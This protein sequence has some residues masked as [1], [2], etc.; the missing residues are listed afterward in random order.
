MVSAMTPLLQKHSGIWI[1][2]PGDGGEGGDEQRHE[3]LAEWGDKE[4]CY[5]LELPADVARGFYEG[6]ANQTLWP[7]FHSFPSRLRFDAKGWDSY[8][9]ANRAFCDAVVA[10]HQPGDLIWVHDYHLMLLPKMLRAALPDAV[11]G[12]FLH[13]PF[14]SADI[15][16]ILPRREDVLEG[17]LGAD[18][19][20]FHTH[21]HVQQF[22]SSVLRVLG[23]ESRINEIAIGNR[24]V[25]LEA[26]PIGIAP[27]EYTGLLA[28]DQVTAKHYEEFVSNYKGQRVIVAIDRLDYTKGV[29]ERL[30]SFREL[31]GFSPELKEKVTLIQVAVRP[32]RA[33]ICIRICAQK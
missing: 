19:L 2:W 4:H 22:R 29:P 27:D 20:A 33:S 26:L 15:F 14:P 9:E 31:L 12:F 6:Y 1:G 7:V 32:E 5:A 30:R 17:L 25:H 3:I 28:K 23:L 13:I 18:L 24:A 8:V 21:N 11:I 10:R 16:P